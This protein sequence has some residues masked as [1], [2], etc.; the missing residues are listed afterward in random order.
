MSVLM[1]GSVWRAIR[2]MQGLNFVSILSLRVRND[3]KN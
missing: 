3:R 1:K 2:H